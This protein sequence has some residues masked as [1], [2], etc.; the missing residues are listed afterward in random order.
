MRC[1][2]S[3]TSAYS[4]RRINVVTTAECELGGG[5]PKQDQIFHG[6]TYCSGGKHDMY[7]I[8]D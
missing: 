1:C 6:P 3:C 4:P 7:F 2:S 5:V 8:S